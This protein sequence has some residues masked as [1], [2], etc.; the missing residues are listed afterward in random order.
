VRNTE[1]EPSVFSLVDRRLVDNWCLTSLAAFRFLMI[2]DFSCK[3]RT[4]NISRFTHLREVICYMLYLLLV[5]LLVRYFYTCPFQERIRD[6]FE[7]RKRSISQYVSG[8]SVK[9]AFY[10]VRSD[11]FRKDNDAMR[12]RSLRD[13]V[14][15]IR[16]I[17]VIHFWNVDETD[18]LPLSI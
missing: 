12:N 14:E 4:P 16:S 13:P 7:F 18:I 2:H 11:L 5:I 9:K 1:C 10:P 3:S 8:K 15:S 17:D 6:I